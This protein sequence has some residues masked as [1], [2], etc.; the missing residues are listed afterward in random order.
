M[1]FLAYSRAEILSDSW[2]PM[3][4]EWA[5][6]SCALD[7]LVRKWWISQQRCIGEKIFRGLLCSEFYNGSGFRSFKKTF[8]TPY[9]L[10]NV[11][12]S[13]NIARLCGRQSAPRARCSTNR[14]ASIFLSFASGKPCDPI[15]N[16][17]TASQLLSPFLYAFVSVA[18]R[19]TLRDARTR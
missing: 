15:T 3:R 14:Y 19:E 1:F 12:S 2:Q 6:R 11:T 7:W 13:L 9:L 16:D 8:G 17:F 4:L 18:L 10:F 5:C